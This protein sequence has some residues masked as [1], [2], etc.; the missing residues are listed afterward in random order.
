MPYYIVQLEEPANAEDR[1]LGWGLNASPEGAAREYLTS[2]F[3]TDEFVV[4]MTGVSP[5]YKFVCTRECDSGQEIKITIWV[6]EDHPSTLR[7]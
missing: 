3:G 1:G 7:M 2:H 5:W 4:L 6:R